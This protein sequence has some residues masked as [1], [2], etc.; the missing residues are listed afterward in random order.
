MAGSRVKESAAG[1]ALSIPTAAAGDEELPALARKVLDE[2]IADHKA[3]KR[4]VKKWR[5]DFQRV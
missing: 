5:P 4:L 3:I 2:K 1:K